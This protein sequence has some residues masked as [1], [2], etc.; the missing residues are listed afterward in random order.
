MSKKEEEVCR[1]KCL[2]F[3]AFGDVD[4]QLQTENL[5]RL[6]SAQAQQIRTSS[7]FQNRLIFKLQ[8]LE[9]KECAEV[10]NKDDILKLDLRS[11]S[12]SNPEEDTCRSESL[13][14]EALLNLGLQTGLS[15]LFSL[16]QQNWSGPDEQHPLSSTVISTAN[17]MLL[18]FPPLSLLAVPPLGE[19]ALDNVATFLHTSAQIPQASTSCYELLLSLAIQRGRCSDVLHWINTALTVAIQNPSLT[20]NPVIFN[21]AVQLAQGRTYDSHTIY[22]K[23]AAMYLTEQIVHFTSRNK[24]DIYTWG[25][26]LHSPKIWDDVNDVEK[27]ETGSSCTYVIHTN[28]KV[29]CWKDNHFSNVHFPSP[30][31][32]VSLSQDNESFILA[33]TEDHKVYSWGNGSHGRLGHGDKKDYNFPKEI[34]SLPPI[35]C[36][37]AGH[38]H[39]AAITLDGYLY[40]WGEGSLG[41]LGHK[42]GIVH[43]V[44]TLVKNLHNVGSVSC[45]AQHTLIV[46]KDG[47]QVWS[48]GCGNNGE[49]GQGDT[50]C[51]YTPKLI[52]FFDGVIMKK[53]IAS[54]RFSLAL[55]VSGDLWIWGKTPWNT[56]STVP[57]WINSISSISNVSTG[58]FH[59]IVILE[60]RSVYSWGLNTYGKC[61]LG[62]TSLKVK[63]PKRLDIYDIDGICAGPT[64][65]YAWTMR[66]GKGCF[67]WPY[68]NE[69]DAKTFSQVSDILNNFGL[70]DFNAK[71]NS[72]FDEDEQQ[73]F[74]LHIFTLLI[75]YFETISSSIR[76][77]DWSAEKVKL[78]DIIFKFIDKENISPEIYCKVIKC[79]E[80]G[81]QFLQPQLKDRVR[82]CYKLL[83]MNNLSKGQQYKLK[84]D[85]E[86]LNE[87]GIISGLICESEE[88]KDAAKKLLQHLVYKM[89]HDFVQSL[90]ECDSKMLDL[91]MSVGYSIHWQYLI[92][93]KSSN[94]FKDLRQYIIEVLKLGECLIESFIKK[95]KVDSTF[96]ISHTKPPHKFTSVFESTL[97]FLINN[98]QYTPLSIK[99]L[100]ET[101]LK[102]NCILKDENSFLMD[103]HVLISILSGHIIGSKISFFKPQECSVLYMCSQT[104]FKYVILIPHV[105]KSRCSISNCFEEMKNVVCC[106]IC[107]L[108]SETLGTLVSLAR[109]HF[110]GNQLESILTSFN[111]DYIQSVQTLLL[112]LEGVQISNNNIKILHAIYYRMFSK[113]AFECGTSQDDFQPKICSLL[114]HLLQFINIEESDELNIENYWKLFFFGLLLNLLEFSNSHDELDFST[115][116]LEFKSMIPII[117]QS[118]SPS[119]EDV[120]FFFE[121]V[122]LHKKKLSDNI[123]EAEQ[124]LSEVYFMDKKHGFHEAAIQILCELM[125]IR[126]ICSLDKIYPNNL[127][128]KVYS[129]SRYNSNRDSLGIKLAQLIQCSSESSE[130][131][132]DFEDFLTLKICC[133]SIEVYCSE[134]VDIVLSEDFLKALCNIL[135]NNISNNLRS[136]V[137]RLIFQSIL[138]ARNVSKKLLNEPCCYKISLI[139]QDQLKV[140]FGHD[141]IL[142]DIVNFICVLTSSINE[143]V[144]PSFLSKFKFGFW[145]NNLLE[146][147][148]GCPSILELSIVRC[149]GKIL[150]HFE[151]GRNREH[152]VRKLFSHIYTSYWNSKSSDLDFTNIQRTSYNMEFNLDNSYH[153]ILQD[154]KTV[155]SSGELFGYCMANRCISRGLVYWKISILKDS[156]G[157]DGI[158]I[159]VTPGI[160]NNR[161][162]KDM[163]LYMSSGQLSHKEGIFSAH[164][165]SF[166]KGDIIVC[167]LNK[168]D[169]SLSFSKNGGPTLLAFCDLP[170]SIELYPVVSFS[171]TK[172][173][174]SISNLYELQPSTSTLYLTEPHLGSLSI[175]IAQ[176]TVEII[177]S[178][179]NG[180]SQMWRSIIDS[181]SHNIVLKSYELVKD[182]LKDFSSLISQSEKLRGS[183]D[184]VLE[185]I[186]PLLALLSDVDSGLCLGSY[187]RYKEFKRGIIIG[188][189]WG[190][191]INVKIRWEDDGSSSFRSIQCLKLIKKIDSPVHKIFMYKY[192]SE[193][194]D[195]LLLIYTFSEKLNLS[196]FSSYKSEEERNKNKENPASTSQ[197]VENM[198]DSLVSSI[199]DEV[200][201]KSE[202]GNKV[203]NCEGNIEKSDSD[204]TLHEVFFKVIALQFSSIKAMTY[205]ANNYESNASNALYNESQFYEAVS[206]IRRMSTPSYN[207]SFSRLINRSEIE[208]TFSILNNLR[209]NRQGSQMSSLD[210]SLASSSEFE[211]ANSSSNVSSC[212][213]DIRSYFTSRRSSLDDTMINIASNSV[214]VRRTFRSD[215]LKVNPNIYLMEHLKDIYDY[216]CLN[217]HDKEKINVEDL[218]WLGPINVKADP[219]GQ[220][221]LKNG[222]RDLN[223]SSMVDISEEINNRMYLQYS[224]FLSLNMKLEE[225]FYSLEYLKKI[226]QIKC[227]QDLLLA[228]FKNVKHIPIPEIINISFCYPFLFE[229]ARMMG[230]TDP[231]EGL[232]F[233]NEKELCCSFGPDIEVLKVILYEAKN[234]LPS[235]LALCNICVTNLMNLSKDKHTLTVNEKVAIYITQILTEIVVSILYDKSLEIYTLLKNL[236]SENSPQHTNSTYLEDKR[237]IVPTKIIDALS[238]VILSQRLSDLDSMT[239]CKTWAAKMIVKC[240]GFHLSDEP[241]KGFKNHSDILGALPEDI[242]SYQLSGH[243]HKIVSMTSYNDILATGSCDGTIRLWKD[244]EYKRILIIDFD[245][246]STLEISVMS[247]Q[248]L[249]WSPSGKYL[250][251]SV[252]NIIY[253]WDMEDSEENCNQ[254][255]QL[256]PIIYLCWS[257]NSEIEILLAARQNGTVFSISTSL[258]Q[259]KELDELYI[260]QVNIC[261][262]DSFTRPDNCFIISYS[263]GTIRIFSIIDFS[264]TISHEL[265]YERKK[266]VSVH[267]DYFALYSYDENDIKIINNEKMNLSFHSS[268][269]SISI[270]TLSWSSNSDYLAI[271]YENGEILVL[272]IDQRKESI[273]LYGSQIVSYLLFHKSDPY[274]L[275]SG[276]SKNPGG[277]VNIWSIL[278]QSV[279]RT[280]IGDG[281]ITCL[282]WINSKTLAVGFCNTENVTLMNLPNEMDNVIIASK[283]RAELFEHLPFEQFAPYF[284]A[285]IKQFGYFIIEQYEYEKLCLSEGFQLIYS[286]FLQ[287]LSFLAFV[288]N[289]N[290]VLCSL[291]DSRWK[292]LS[293][294]TQSMTFIS[295]LNKR[296][297]KSDHELLKSLFFD[298]IKKDVNLKDIVWTPEADSHLMK[299]YIV[300]PSD[301]QPG[302]KSSVYLVGNGQNGQLADLGS[303]SIPPKYADSFGGSSSV[304][305]GLQVTFALQP[306][307]S[308]YACGEGSY[309]KL[310]LG[311]SDDYFS[312]TP[313]SA[314]RGFVITQVATSTQGGCG[315]TLALTQ[316]GEVFSWG[317][318][319]DGKLGHGNTERCRRPKIISS[320]SG[321]FAT[322]VAVGTSHSAVLTDKGKI[323]TFGNGDRGRLG[324]GN[325]QTK[326]SP[327]QISSLRGYFVTYVA[328]GLEHTMCITRHNGLVNVWSFGDEE[329]GKLGFGYG[330]S[331]SVPQKIN[332][333]W[334]ESVTK[335]CLGRTFSLFLTSGDVFFC[336]NSKFSGMDINSSNMNIQSPKKIPKLENMVDIAVGGDHVLALSKSGFVW[337]WGCNFLGQLGNESGYFY[338]EPIIIEELSGK[339]ILQISAGKN[340]SAAWTS[341]PMPTNFNNSSPTKPRHNIGRPNSLPDEFVSLLP[342]TSA[343][344]CLTRLKLLHEISNYIVNVWRLF[345]VIDSDFYWPP[346]IKDF[347]IAMSND[348]V[349]ESLSPLVATLPLMQTLMSTMT[350]SNVLRNYGPQVTVR[351]LFPIGSSSI[352]SQIAEQVFYIDPKELRL[353]YRSWKVK[354]V[355]E[356]ADDAGGVFDDTISEMCQEL[357]KDVLNLLTPTP[358]GI[359]DIG[360]NQDKYLLNSDKNSKVDMRH[361]WFL[362]V[363]CGVALRTRKPIAINL[364]PLVWKLILEIKT[365]WKD[366]EDVDL[367]YSRS[368]H[369][370]A[371]SFNPDNE[372]DSLLPTDYFMG[373][374]FSG[375]EVPLYPGSEKIRLSYENKDE[376]VKAA[377]NQ[378]F[379]EMMPQVLAVRK[380]LSALAPYPILKLLPSQTIESLVCGE[381]SFPLWILKKIARYRDMDPSNEVIVWLWEILEE[382]NN[383]LKILFLIF[384]SGRSR[385]PTH[386]FDVSQRFQI[387]RVERPE[388]GL[389]T[390]QTCFFQLRLPPYTSK[391]I[392]RNRLIYAIKHCRTIDMDSYML[393]RNNETRPTGG[394]DAG[395]N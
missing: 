305:C 171:S 115:L 191:S 194:I 360:S 226:I 366:L 245:D 219:L 137:L 204:V 140:N 190:E 207:I 357:S 284:R 316:S 353:P 315:H 261:C 60:N 68:S 92:S 359:S 69:P 178:L 16:L 33:L 389:P 148:T 97:L 229:F 299:W 93:Q 83:K 119:I 172:A 371:T 364:A 35:M 350:N 9:N 67:H 293:S 378:R 73:K 208:R 13:Q 99:K 51:L 277:I 240:I 269:K 294:F 166:S 134:R 346:K 160:I 180:K 336:G 113:L 248:I 243:A 110:T 372:E 189:G 296:N 40:T 335:I 314:L 394:G 5:F 278:S 143:S 388:N 279:I 375:R 309:G 155:V 265:S 342:T 44:P 12:F 176:E 222:L 10:E 354:L 237:N 308:L 210:N 205:L 330:G 310:G 307:G 259:M 135:A 383:D 262:L 14:N 27:I 124:L 71:L 129:S 58:G 7:Y 147:L 395:H 59:L 368:L 49:L 103:I 141:E 31:I 337:G 215:I 175:S 312:L 45:G 376:Y 131:I 367:S 21:K 230:H 369:Y 381:S 30:I 139:I 255:P 356:A 151:I 74:L 185:A 206:M 36:I 149:L 3:A 267:E 334:R 273:H 362:G 209:R 214:P 263:D 90:F 75:S 146:C 153:C 162:I 62:L 116:L 268:L 102:L 281:G 340:H 370:V 109:S 156:K 85:L 385:L 391:E 80:V 251:L 202:S 386:A 50:G 101:S 232:Y 228:Y 121:S 271:G 88:G 254:I 233:K 382:F 339:G 43:F 55:S 184:N 250:V 195:M 201:G 174:I 120:L 380:G 236:S 331:R 154:T 87:P 384:V 53:V 38:H 98:P 260:S 78:E 64:Q 122:H 288:L 351:R 199:I 165:P 24:Q 345:P 239:S 182:L 212:Y 26:D 347:Y 292:W 79:I 136:C 4:F 128:E 283:C 318:G 287:N 114:D 306:N 164:L 257:P 104:F 56:S 66:K 256:S 247:D 258:L 220:Q 130:A 301:W 145:V 123:F 2:G 218:R 326:K 142:S 107:T 270:T 244:N 86:S 52:N 6:A 286:Q 321:N 295:L 150:S 181:C 32:D 303:S 348:A 213:F 28:G 358:N 352:F 274:I 106:D 84:M 193:L 57:K 280:L 374:S 252:G 77:C 105:Y 238:S 282:H 290:T 317:D 8:G 196:V 29:S 1:W 313:V 319:E 344:E 186:Y 159:G 126:P 200:T 338:K 179:Y 249:T 275:A 117:L 297:A 231:M 377:L 46:S 387:L 82:R 223:T 132:L 272:Q 327:E 138:L 216:D 203:N 19:T 187:V 224:N 17:N 320:L 89:H 329:Y 365:T 108:N 217:E 34:S 152:I 332:F 392:M 61:G 157:V 20:I 111:L 125:S 100:R 343:D 127:S 163:W 11:E 302:G 328:C 173:K 198:T 39:A 94:E 91:E 225:M 133:L 65:S 161:S 304:I 300:Y 355:G 241:I 246:E 211:S 333:A 167:I 325:F 168:E 25:C 41:R 242:Y 363:L 266:F 264:V 112:D 18:S 48:F 23:E 170:S 177:R 322:F 291:P 95:V 158:S 253:I 289:L 81:A 37:S 221:D 70:S 47:M 118:D 393:T 234:K 192:S 390:A 235:F 379:K 183:I 76:S 63:N 341:P 298:E 361:F 188:M 54:N 197:A 227:T 72:H 276:S 285:F 96:I 22:L 349:R 144:V 373:I 324:H 311:N 15:L 169:S 42:D 323:F